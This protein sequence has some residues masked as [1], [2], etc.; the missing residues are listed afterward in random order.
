MTHTHVPDPSRKRQRTEVRKQ[1]I[2]RI[3]ARLFA[4]NGYHSTG[5]SELS[6]AVGLGKGALYYHIGSKE[7][8]LYEISAEHVQQMVAY[9]EALV[10]REDLSAPEKVRS[11]SRTLLRTISENLPEVTVFFHEIRTLGGEHGAPRALRGDLDSGH[12]RRRHGR[13]LPRPRSD[14]HQGHSRPAQLLLHLDATR[15]PAVTRRHIRR[16]LRPTAQRLSRRRAL[17]RRSIP[18]CPPPCSGVGTER[19][20]RAVSP[21]ASTRSGGARSRRSAAC[22][23]ARR[24]KTAVGTDGNSPPDQGPIVAVADGGE[25]NS[26]DVFTF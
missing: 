15:G 4:A 7:E 20:R 14:R 23:H 13:R 19:C 11:L 16:L 6:E 24:R 8:L 12:R 2:A 17:T 10:A 25:K 21:P 1:Q 18:A 9:G 26:S 5:M 3:A 22:G